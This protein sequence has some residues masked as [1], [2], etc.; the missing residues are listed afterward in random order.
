MTQEQA[1]GTPRWRRAL[2][3]MLLLAGFG[4]LVFLVVDAGPSTVWRAIRTAGPWLPLIMGFGGGWFAGEVVA[5]RILL[6]DVARRVPL[7][8]LVR[9]N[10]VAYAIV[11]LAPLGKAGSEI[12]RAAV[13]A[14]HVGGARAAAAAA[15]VQAASLIG[16]ALVSVPCAIAVFSALGTS[17]I[18][19]WLVVGNGVVTAVLGGAA[20]LLTRL[21]RVGERLAGRFEALKVTG[22]ELD[23][24]LRVRRSTF[25]KAVLA[26]FTARLS[27][28]A[29]YGVLLLAVGGSLGLGPALATQGVHLVGAAAG[30][31]VPGQV[32]VVEGA[33][34][35]FADALGLD[36]ARALSI[37]LVSRVS[38]MLLA[39][40]A[41][42]VLAFTRRGSPGKPSDAAGSGRPVR[43]EKS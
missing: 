40:V 18:L 23:E 1:G 20:L 10:L 21:G 29:Q 33:Y 26:T 6:E 11:V 3:W 12:A 41:L 22:P 35:V 34:R 37:G 30:D 17:S 7:P 8:A 16:N 4:L 42:L 2:S 27:Q 25:A 5:H 43:S 28:T 24:A 14:D 36:V 13:V 38:A 19:G 15:N 9:A 32:G 39:A 31:L